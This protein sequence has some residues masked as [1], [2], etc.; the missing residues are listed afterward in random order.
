MSL[1]HPLLH[2]VPRITGRI[3]LPDRVSSNPWI[4][5][6]GKNSPLKLSTQGPVQCEATKPDIGN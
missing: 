6:P 1:L 3:Y 5:V 2:A 4:T